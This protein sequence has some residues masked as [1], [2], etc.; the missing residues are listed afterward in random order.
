VPRG[1]RLR[2]RAGCEKSF[3][4][5][6]GVT[7][8][9]GAHP[10]IVTYVPYGRVVRIAH[11]TDCF[12]PRTGG[13]ET[14]VLGLAERQ[15]AAGHDVVVLTATP[16]GKE[17][18]GSDRV[19]S[20]PVERIAARVPFDLPVHPN[21]R[22]NVLRVLRAQRVDVVHVH[23]G[24]ASPFAWG[25]IRAARQARIPTVVTVHSMWDPL[26]RVGNR[27]LD[28]TSWG[29]GSGVVLT[30]VGSVA[31][32]CVREAL[33][34]PVMVLPNG[35]D[36]REWS[37]T[38]VPSPDDVLRVVSVLRLA[39][40]KRAQPLVSILHRAIAGSGGRIR[41]T[42]IGDGPDTGRVQRYIDRHGL[43]D[44]IN[45]VGRLPHTRIR[46][47]FAISDVFLQASVRESFGIAALEAR[48]SGLAIVARSQAGSSD[49]VTDGVEGL[50]G[51]DDAGLVSALLTLQADPELLESMIANNTTVPPIQAWPNV[52]GQ[53]ERAYDIARGVRKRALG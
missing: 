42:L 29:M 47:Q 1:G 15:I 17:R 52:L 25:G 22:N 19:G 45:L 20:V 4:V 31:A 9:H 5:G 39:P 8:H 36:P 49:F 38:R 46:A 10:G 30:A 28:R 34:Q 14:Q 40:R 2:H 48:T 37:V 13:I 41:A 24:A 32:E 43:G 18:S 6:V 51:H 23:A 50:L 7:E 16:G 3:V 21:T 12:A 53:V 35:I 11:I 44:V 33:G 27:M 26:S